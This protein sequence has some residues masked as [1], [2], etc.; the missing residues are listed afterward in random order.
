MALQFENLTNSSTIG[1][2]YELSQK[3]QSWRERCGQTAL[4]NEKK[5]A[6]QRSTSFTVLLILQ[7]VVLE[8]KQRKRTS[9]STIGTS[10]FQTKKAVT[11]QYVILYTS[12]NLIQ[13]Q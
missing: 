9:Y 1:F 6:L 2:G 11:V 7:D 3:S 8:H 4:V 12:N 13:L 10:S 5:S